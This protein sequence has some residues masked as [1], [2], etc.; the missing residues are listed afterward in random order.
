METQLIEVVTSGVKT[1][2]IDK[3]Y[4]ILSFSTAE[5][6]QNCYFHYDLEE[7]PERMVQVPYIIGNHN[8]P[9]FNLHQHSVEE[10]NTL[11]ILT[12]SSFKRNF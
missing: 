8:V 12:S 10:L 4:D 9:T 7:M 11:V 5:S 6:R 2:L 1:H 3:E